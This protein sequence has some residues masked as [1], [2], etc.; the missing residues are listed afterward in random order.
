MADL[1]P[2]TTGPRV[3]GVASNPP[4]STFGPR[5]LGDYEFVWMLDGAAAYRWAGRRFE[6]PQEAVVLCR[7]TPAGEADAFD[8]DARRRSRHAFVHF[9][10][11]RVPRSFPPAADWP[12]VRRLAAQ[13]VF[14]PTFRHLRSLMS[15]PADR[16]PD[17]LVRQALGTLLGTFV[18]G[19]ADAG[20]LP[21]PDWP[22][23]VRRAAAHFAGKLDRDPAAPVTLAE[24]AG[25]ACVTPAYL[26]RAYRRATGRTPLGA[27]R[28]A[29]LDRA[30]AMLARS[31]E[32]VSVIA[33]ACGFASPFHFSRR[34]SGQFGRSPT[35][36]RDAARAGGA[37]PLPLP[38]GHLRL[39]SD[40][41]GQPRA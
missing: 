5:R 31:N 13:D 16:R 40:D 33:A 4:G 20:P 9:D 18:L 38:R 28:E 25:A 3:I 6:V 37:L 17:A 41:E 26:C 12:F 14:R 35:A 27:V 23:P 22:E 8:W 7:P 30:L 1:L 39:A 19:H 32:P 2:T 34:F 36:V 21:A 11:A 10:V 29:R 15:I 24:L